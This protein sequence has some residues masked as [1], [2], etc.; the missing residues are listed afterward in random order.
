[1]ARRKTQV[2]PLE[3]IREIPDELWARIEPTLLEFWPAKATGRPPAEWRRMLEGIIFRMRSGC[4]WGQL[5]ERFGPKSTVHGWFRRWAEGGVLEEIWAVILA[6]CDE[7]G[8][9]DWRWQSA[10]A[11]LGKARSGGGERR[12]GTPPTAARRAPRRAC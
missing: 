6:E 1:M 12:A 2:P 9:G 7:L 4:Q 5:P 10:D 3:T 8:G 11:M